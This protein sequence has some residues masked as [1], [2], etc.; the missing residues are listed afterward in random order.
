MI[1]ADLPD[2]DWE[3]TLVELVKNDQLHRH[4]RTCQKYRNRNCR[5]NFGRFFTERTI[6]AKPLSDSLTEHEKAEIML[7]RITVLN[8]VKAYT[9]SEFNPVKHNFYDKWRDDFE[10]VGSINCILNQLGISEEDYYNTLSISDDFQVHLKWLPNS[11]FV[12]SF[13]RTVLL[14]WEA[15]FYIQPVFN[16]YKAVTYMSIYLSI[17]EDECSHAM[18]QVFNEAMASK[19]TNYDQMKSIAR[20][21]SM[22]RECSVQEAVYHIMPELWLWKIFSAVVFTNTNIPENHFRVCLD[23]R[24]IKDFPENSTDIFIKNM[25]DRYVDWPDL[26]F[27]AGKYAMADQMCYAEFLRYYYLF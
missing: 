14:A 8:K 1:S 10:H 26:M 23:E 9:D 13:F 24:E 6:V 7:V 3:P 11:C 2:E 18:N 27:A 19:L 22:K 20:A 5:T 17:T 12:N 15:N 25:V 4:S 16:H 21:Y